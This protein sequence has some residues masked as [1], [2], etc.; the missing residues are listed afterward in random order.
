MT[1]L[2]V[3]MREAII[4]NAL[5]KS[6]VVK[7][8]SEYQL[9]RRAW[10]TDVADASVGGPEVLAQLEAANQKVA[11][12]V[13]TLPEKFQR[14]LQ[15]GPMNGSIYASFGGRRTY[16]NDWEGERPAVSSCLFAA[17][18]PLSIQFEE[19]ENEDKAIREKRE[20]IST[21]V[22]AAL[23][24]VNTI[25][26]LLTAWPEAAEL[27]PTYAAPKPTLPALCVADLNAAIGLPTGET[28]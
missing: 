3:S 5:E 7:A 25:K 27:L 21:Q 24:N 28:E 15:V 16:I 14:G 10:A 4:D 26:Q 23:S 13:K 22:K 20:A 8:R 9:K 18:D 2:T 17:D 19:L 1:K 12:I 6:G 11:K